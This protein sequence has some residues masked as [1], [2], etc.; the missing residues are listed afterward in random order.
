MRKIN[1]GITFAAIMAAVMMMATACGGKTSSNETTADAA[2]ET[3]ASTTDASAADEDEDEDETEVET[4][5]VTMAENAGA[6]EDNGKFADASGKYEI[7]LPDGWLIDKDSDDMVAVFTSPDGNDIIEITYVK[8]DDVSGER[9]VLP[10]DADEFEEYISRGED[11]VEIVTYDIDKKDNG[12]ESF[13]YAVKFTE[14]D[15][16][17][18][19]NEA[20]GEYNAANEEYVYANATIT[21]SGEDIIKTVSEAMSSFKILK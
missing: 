15:S 21:S 2:A 4:V 11:T 1:K 10:D 17:D 3:T 9:E 16:E 18:K 20:I 6:I 12:D 7:T 5:G 13:H 8:G 14:E 19:Y